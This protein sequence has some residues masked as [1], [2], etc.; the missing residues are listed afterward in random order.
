MKK[1]GIIFARKSTWR[2]R[3]DLEYLD[4]TS[5]RK[6][7]ARQRH[8][9][10]SQDSRVRPLK[11]FADYASKE[12]LGRV[13]AGGFLHDLIRVSA[14]GTSTAPS[15]LTNDEG[16]KNLRIVV[17]PSPKISHLFG[18]SLHSTPL[19]LLDVGRT[20]REVRFLQHIA[21]RWPRPKSFF[22]ARWGRTL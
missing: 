14:D 7:S 13:H 3:L 5:N 19:G 15:K 18:E 8:E 12:T 22:P 4:E 1:N 17:S 10:G 20:A 21:D 16:K 11:Q 2:S 6:D 9:D